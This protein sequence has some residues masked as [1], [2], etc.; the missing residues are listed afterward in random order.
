MVLEMSRLNRELTLIILISIITAAL[1]VISS[2]GAS[3]I[4]ETCSS[5]NP[6][7]KIDDSEYLSMF[8]FFKT[9][10]LL[11]SIRNEPEYQEIYYELEM[12]YNNTHEKV[13]KWL[14]EQGR[15]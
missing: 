12:K 10:P 9:D 11:E 1:L 15:L 14:E 13:R 3:V 6:D 8:W 2:I 7:I 5:N 4:G